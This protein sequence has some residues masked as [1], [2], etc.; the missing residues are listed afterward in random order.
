MPRTTGYY[1]PT[2]TP[3]PREWVAPPAGAFI[4]DGLSQGI[5]G[6]TQNLSAMK[7]QKSESEEKARLARA[8]RDSLVAEGV[9]QSLAEA[10][11]LEY[12]RQGTQKLMEAYTNRKQ[13][14]ADIQAK[15]A[16]TAKTVTETAEIGPNAATS[17]AAVAA[18]TE[19][20][21]TE[22]NLMPRETGV[23]ETT[24]AAGVMGAKTNRLKV[25][26]DI[27]RETREFV[28][29]FDKDLSGTIDRREKAEFLKTSIRTTRAKVQ[30]AKETPAG[31]RDTATSKMAE[32]TDDDIYREAMA[33][34]EAEIRD[35]EFVGRN[36]DKVGGGADGGGMSKGQELMQWILAKKKEPGFQPSSV[37]WGAISQK[38]PDLALP[39]ILRSAGIDPAS[40][41]L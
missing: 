28:K 3:P 36:V 30:K 1:T 16:Q 20:T 9:E 39:N 33:L 25:E 31:N 35:Y 34:A 21:I 2:E 13:V 23:R 6:V 11:A 32:W 41:G 5:G 27:E 18:G 29:D 19:Q 15:N 37:D 40:V 12:A 26:S 8:L 17:R 10:A 14:A 7:A 4:L 22:T 24:A 38:Y